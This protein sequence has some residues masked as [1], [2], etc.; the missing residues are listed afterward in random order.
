MPY[1]SADQFTDLDVDAEAEAHLESDEVAKH[2]TL[3][4]EPCADGDE[5]EA[6]TFDDMNMATHLIDGNE[7]VNDLSDG[8]AIPSPKS[9]NN[10]VAT[11]IA[12]TS[13]PEPTPVPKIAPRKRGR[14]RKYPL[15]DVVA[16]VAEVPGSVSASTPPRK[17]GRPAK[18]PVGDA[19]TTASQG[20]AVTDFSPRKRGRPAKNSPASIS[21]RLVAATRR[22]RTKVVTES[23]Q[24][25]L[26][27]ASDFDQSPS[28]TRSFPS[29][30]RAT[31]SS[32]IP[33]NPMRNTSSAK[34]VGFAD[35]ASTV[36]PED[37]TGP[38]S[39]DSVRGIIRDVFFKNAIQEQDV[40]VLPQPAA[41][42]MHRF[43]GYGTPAPQSDLMV[44]IENVETIRHLLF[45]AEN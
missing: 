20:S 28:F 41:L 32:F 14:P 11:A 7:D 5:T 30:S 45:E 40:W 37:R 17:R 23:Q 33:V 34:H 19:A 29:L 43:F 27:P 9:S 3:S 31:T 38:C 39:C 18:N 4:D 35:A 2:A 15:P 10:A 25:P 36:S 16:N 22:G 44:P 12:P 1:I 21:N 26:A 24:S 42:E 6:Q 8:S 13:S